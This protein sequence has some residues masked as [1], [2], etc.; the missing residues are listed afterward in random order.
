MNAMRTAT[1]CETPLLLMRCGLFNATKAIIKQPR[2]I[3]RRGFILTRQLGE[4]I[5][6]ELRHGLELILCRAQDRMVRIPLLRSAASRT[7]R[8][9]CGTRRGRGRRCGGHRRAR[10]LVNPL[11]LVVA[12]HHVVLAHAEETSDADD[13]AVH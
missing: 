5:V 13:D 4:L 10:G 12:D 7:L 3:E 6:L 11:E 9:V 1:T 8:R 2:R